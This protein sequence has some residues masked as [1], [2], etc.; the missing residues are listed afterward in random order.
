MA[1]SRPESE[2]SLDNQCNNSDFLENERKEVER[3]GTAV[4]APESHE[5]LFQEN[6]DAKETEES[7]EA[8][9]TSSA[10]SGFVRD[11]ESNPCR[12]SNSSVPKAHAHKSDYVSQNEDL[13]LLWSESEEECDSKTWSLSGK[14]GTGEYISLH[15]L[16]CWNHHVLDYYVL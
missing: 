1:A 7:A 12:E 10:H 5:D 15:A 9:N 16:S 4:E 3:E 8:E 6:T 13:G 14:E 11:G 2:E